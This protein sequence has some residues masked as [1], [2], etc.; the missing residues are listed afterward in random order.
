MQH[1]HT[2]EKSRRVRAGERL[3]FV[4]PSEW[5]TYNLW[6]IENLEH[7]IEKENA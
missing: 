5:H 6:C 1:N 7:M 2:E 4:N 3:A